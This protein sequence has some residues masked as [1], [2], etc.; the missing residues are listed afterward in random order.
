VTLL[1]ADRLIKSFGGVHA[2]RDVGFRL[3]RGER[4]AVIGPNG[5]GKST[6]FAMIGGQL[7]PDGGR[8]RLDDRDVTGLPAHR[9]ARAGVARTFQVAATF[10]SMTVAENVQLALLGRH[11]R[12]L[13]LWRAARFKE[14]IPAMALLERLGMGDQADRPAAVLA[15]GDLKRLELALAL[16]LEP[17]LLLMDEPTAG[18]AAEERHGLMALTGDVVAERGIGLLFTEHD[19]DVVFAH[20]DRVLVLARGEV[21]AEGAPETIR[22]DRDVRAL[23]LGDDTDEAA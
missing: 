22:A 3:E 12:L 9:L 1:V 21:V 6:L 20:A 5:A 10:L 11:R 17:E 14:R 23:Y 16:A 2:V 18:M 13:G 7:R 19:M 8:V 4:L 15:Y